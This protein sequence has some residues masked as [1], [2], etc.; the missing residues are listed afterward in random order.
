MKVIG[1]PIDRKYADT[2]INVITEQLLI[3]FHP[4]IIQ[5]AT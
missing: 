3:M 4:K 5:I 2:Y 1:N